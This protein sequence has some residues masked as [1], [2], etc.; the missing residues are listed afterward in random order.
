MPP[1]I[2]PKSARCNTSTSAAS[3]GRRLTHL[4]AL[5]HAGTGRAVIGMPASQRSRSSA[6]ASAEPYRRAG[7]FCQALQADRLQV[8]V[9]LGIDRTRPRRLLVQHLTHDLPG[10]V[11]RERRLAGQRLVERRAQ[12]VD[13]SRRRHR[14]GAAAGLLRRHVGGRAHHRAG[15]RRRRAAVGPDPLG[16]AEVGHVRLVMLGQQDIRRFDVPVQDRPLVGV[17]HGA[18]DLGHQRRHGAP[19]RP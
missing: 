4:T 18:G 1:P 11:A 15:H 14:L 2:S 6:S 12:A 17:V 10:R 19:A 7:S 8:P 5:S 9:E 16:Q 3:A 13:V